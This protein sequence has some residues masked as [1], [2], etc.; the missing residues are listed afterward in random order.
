MDVNP[1]KRRT[2]KKSYA[3]AKSR[4]PRT[5]STPPVHKFTRISAINQ[6]STPLMLKT[7]SSGSLFFSDGTNLADNLQ[8]DFSLQQT[9]VYLGGVS[10]WAINLT[11]YTEFTALF[12]LYRIDSVDVLLIP[13]F[14][15]GSLQENAN[16]ATGTFV[17]V[18][19][20][21]AYGLPSI[22]H[23][24]DYDD[25]AVANGQAVQ[26]YENCKYVPWGGQYPIKLRSFRPRAITQFYNTAVSAA[27]G[28]GSDKPQWLDCNYAAAKHYGMKMALQQ[29]GNN[30]GPINAVIG[31]FDV[32]FKYHLSFKNTR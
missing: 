15:G 16:P 11:N 7:D 9:T 3:L 19:G 27:Y 29:V 23:C 14:L 26:Q 25:V 6:G 10:R 31:Y 22:M 2:S 17:P 20:L 5:I 12:D 8:F 30:L 21:A 28:P 4:V 18:T 13:S 32:V 24:V 1:K